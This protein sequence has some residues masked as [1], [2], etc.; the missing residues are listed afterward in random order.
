MIGVWRASPSAEAIPVL[1]ASMPADRL[2]G[3]DWDS[4]RRDDLHDLGVVRWLPTG[5][6]Q[7]WHDCA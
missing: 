6:C 5:V 4:I 2:V 1:Y 7:A 3:V